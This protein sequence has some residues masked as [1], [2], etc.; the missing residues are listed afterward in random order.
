M[1]TV[2]TKASLIRDA[3]KG[4]LK[5]RVAFHRQFQG[6]D[7]P[8]RLKGIRPITGANTTAIFFETAE[9]KKSPLYLPAASLIEYTDDFIRIYAPGF[10][11]PNNWEQHILTKWNEIE[12]T[13]KFQEQRKVDFLTDCSSTFYQKKYFFE[14]HNANYL[15]G[16]D[17]EKGLKLDHYRYNDNLPDFIQDDKIKGELAIEYQIIR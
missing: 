1:P 16:F 17:K 6:Q 11:C 8:A 3:K 5:T 2:K 9:G 4:T 15:R 13:T 12:S 7:L 14:E 10:R